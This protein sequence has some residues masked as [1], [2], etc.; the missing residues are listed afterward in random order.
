[1]QKEE[2]KK[3]FERIADEAIKTA[4]QAF[5][6]NLPHDYIVELHGAGIRGEQMPLSEV[7]EHLY[8]DADTS[9]L[10]ID[11][12]VKY[13][14]NDVAVLLVRPSDHA[15]APYSQTWNKPEGNG[16]FKV[17]VPMNLADIGK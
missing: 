3:L 7:V 15:P 4:E 8:I 6:K 10:I 16:P 14:K 1:M 12:G 13:V 11:V 9:Y 17:I 5:A 2:F